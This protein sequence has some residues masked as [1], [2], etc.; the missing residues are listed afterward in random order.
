[1]NN[2]NSAI[3]LCTYM[4]WLV[5]I[6][7]DDAIYVPDSFVSHLGAVYCK[8]KCSRAFEFNATFVLVLI[9]FELALDSFYGNIVRYR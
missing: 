5:A 1:M 6:Y 9:I 7:Q 2:A 8:A 4:Y 3:Y